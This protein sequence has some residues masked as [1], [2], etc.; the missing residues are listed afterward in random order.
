MS[1]L[2]MSDARAA[3]LAV[4]IFDLHPRPGSPLYAVHWTIAAFVA[5]VAAAFA[6]YV[7]GLGAGADLLRCA[8]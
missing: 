1:P 3:R 8:S 5:T 6:G 7:A 4:A 2:P